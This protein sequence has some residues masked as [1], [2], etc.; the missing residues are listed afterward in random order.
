MV[1]RTAGETEDERDSA[2]FIAQGV[3]ASAIVEDRSDDTC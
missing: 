3:S 2:K 1:S